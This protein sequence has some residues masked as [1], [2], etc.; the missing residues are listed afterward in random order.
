MVVQRSSGPTHLV[1]SKS[2]LVATVGAA[3]HELDI[4]TG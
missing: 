1:P 2:R 4:A 3:E